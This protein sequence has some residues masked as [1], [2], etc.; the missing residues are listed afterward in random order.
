VF[1]GIAY[2]SNVA[3]T[4]ISKDDERSSRSW[5]SLCWKTDKSRCAETIKK[6]KARGISFKSI[7]GDNRL[8]TETH[9]WT[10]RLITSQIIAGSDLLHISDAALVQQANQASLFAEIEP[11]QKQRNNHSPQKSRQR[12]WLYWRWHKRCSGSPCRRRRYFRGQR[13]GCG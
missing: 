10:G 7:S 4:T 1:L 11:N 6:L 8:V 3:G 2:R 12:G 5:V 13:C 9:R